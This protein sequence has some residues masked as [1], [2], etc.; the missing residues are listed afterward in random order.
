[1]SNLGRIN[2]SVVPG[3]MSLSMEPPSSTSKDSWTWENNP[4][5][6]VPRFFAVP[7]S[8]F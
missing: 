7:V 2:Q 6:D 8:H 3:F 1:M 4:M 5:Y